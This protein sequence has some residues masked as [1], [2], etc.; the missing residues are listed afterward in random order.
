[1]SGCAKPCRFDGVDYPSYAAAA[2]ALGV[3]RAAI[4]LRMRGEAAVRR[5]A[6]RR[7]KRR[8]ARDSNRVVTVIEVEGVAYPSLAAAGRGL[9]LSAPAVATRVASDS[10]R[11]R[12]WRKFTKT[13]PPAPREP[14]SRWRA[15]TV[16]GVEYQS[17][18]AAAAALGVSAPA[19]S[20]RVA[21]ERRKAAP[22]APRRR[23]VTVR[24][25]AAS[26]RQANVLGM[27]AN[28]RW[29]PADDLALLEARAAGWHFSKIAAQLG[30]GC[31]DVQCRWHRL[32]VV[33]DIAAQI[34]ALVDAGDTYRVAGAG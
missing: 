13:V 7:A 14:D 30:R 19:I 29:S 21:K 17:Q 28:P 16:G 12:G 18:K 5:A 6:A 25:G 34:A 9:G 10:V 27:F 32:R 1:M 33:P 2:E 26:E 11:W 8:A 24:Q 22:P 20:Q 31:T 3:T 23:V 15:V 4:S